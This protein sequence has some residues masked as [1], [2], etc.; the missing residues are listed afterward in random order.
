MSTTKNPQLPAR[1]RFSRALSALDRA[2]SRPRVGIVVICI[3]A[4]WIITSALVGFPSAL[5]TAF[6]TLIAGLTFAMLFVLQHTQAR[7]QAA[8]QRK[9]DEILLALPGADNTVL[10]I[11]NAADEELR[12]I[13]ES[14]TALR[15]EAIRDSHIGEGRDS[16]PRATRPE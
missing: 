15:E 10:S 2:T 13:G 8:T 4:A 9:L 3:D 14:H 11:E 16:S 12:T 5:E 6:Q 1:S 7:H